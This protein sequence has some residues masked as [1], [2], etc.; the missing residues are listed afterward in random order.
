MGSGGWWQQRVG[1]QE[2]KPSGG[3]ETTVAVAAG[4]LEWD[5]NSSNSSGRS[6]HAKAGVRT[7]SRTPTSRPDPIIRV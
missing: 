5:W 6:D 4:E 1:E 2:M 3:G 7:W